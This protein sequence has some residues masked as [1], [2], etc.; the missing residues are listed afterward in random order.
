MSR[1]VHFEIPADQPGRAIAFYEKVFNWKFS[2]W[3]GPMTYWMI[4]TGACIPA[5][6]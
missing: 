2:K 5:R 3:E 1:P 6:V 4:S